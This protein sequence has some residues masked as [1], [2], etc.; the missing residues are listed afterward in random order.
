MLARGL[1]DTLRAVYETDDNC[2]AVMDAMAKL[3]E[4]PGWY[5]SH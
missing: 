2:V 3:S 1:L 5:F 4:D